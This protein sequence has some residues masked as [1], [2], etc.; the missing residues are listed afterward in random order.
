M[1]LTKLR[2]HEDAISHAQQVCQLE[3]NDPFSFTALSVT[4]QRAGKIPEAED[5]MA[6]SDAPR[7]TPS[8]IDGSDGV[9]R[10]IEAVEFA[11]AKDKRFENRI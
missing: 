10:G 9:G 11:M 5:A 4:L 7:G 8:L 2:R 6:R 3:P 1:V